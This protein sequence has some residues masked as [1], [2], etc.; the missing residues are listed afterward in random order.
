MKVKTEVEEDNSEQAIWTDIAGTLWTSYLTEMYRWP[1]HTQLIEHLEKC[2][3]VN[4][5]Y[6]GMRQLFPQWRAHLY[7]RHKNTLRAWL[8]HYNQFEFLRPGAEAEE[9]SELEQFRGQLHAELSVMLG[10][11]QPTEYEKI[12]EKKR[13]DMMAYRERFHR[14]GVQAQARL[15]ASSTNLTETAQRRQGKERRMLREPIPPSMVVKDISH[16]R[17]QHAVGTPLDQVCRMLEP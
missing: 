17:P 8:V 14:R 1:P 15:K 16:L 12:L 11:P 5:G 4:I 9:P 13:L 10:V 3:K 6:Q 2:K 7:M